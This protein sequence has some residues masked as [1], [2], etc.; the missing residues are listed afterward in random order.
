MKVNLENLILAGFIEYKSAFD[1]G[2]KCF[3]K[4][5]KDNRGTKYFI[6]CKYFDWSNVPNAN[7]SPSF[8]FD[9]QFTKGEDTLNMLL[10]NRK[11]RTI[12]EVEDFFEKAFVN[13]EMNYYD[14]N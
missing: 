11:D 5:I 4:R 13:L 10:L 6:N 9:T 2:C 8:E 14:E 12:Q 7:L 3:Q 1:K